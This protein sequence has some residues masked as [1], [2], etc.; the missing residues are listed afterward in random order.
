MQIF[1]EVLPAVRYIIA[2]TGCFFFFFSPSV[3]DLLVKSLKEHAE[4]GLRTLQ[5]ERLSG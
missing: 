1:G 3:F 5:I 4:T 2:V